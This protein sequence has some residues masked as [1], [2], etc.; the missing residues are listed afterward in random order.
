MRE[1]AFAA[2]IDGR[3]STKSTVASMA[4][5]SHIS[6]ITWRSRGFQTAAER[7]FTAQV[8]CLL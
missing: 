3:P 4:W 2:V 6:P 8:R 1:I 7:G 5:H